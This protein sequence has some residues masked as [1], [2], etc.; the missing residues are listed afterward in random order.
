MPLGIRGRGP[1]RPRGRGGRTITPQ[2]A[3]RRNGG[4]KARS[5][6]LFDLFLLLV[7]TERSEVNT[8]VALLRVRH[9]FSAEGPRSGTDAQETMKPVKD[10]RS[11]DKTLAG[12]D[13]RKARS[14]AEKIHGRIYSDRIYCINTNASRFQGGSFA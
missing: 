10:R 9:G 7:F 8:Y 3:H 5:E 2:H 13:L 11:A 12:L 14:A 6:H 4:P 1:S